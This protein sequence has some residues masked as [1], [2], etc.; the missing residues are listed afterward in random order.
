MSDT[1]LQGL[2]AVIPP[3]GPVFLSMEDLDVAIEDQNEIS[4]PAFHSI[5]Q[6][7]R[8]S[9]SAQTVPHPQSLPLLSGLFFCLLFL[10]WPLPVGANAN[11]SQ[12]STCIRSSEYRIGE[13]FSSLT[14]FLFVAITLVVVW[15]LFRRPW[16]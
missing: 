11:F 15:V 4:M 2:E 1:R 7:S 9:S 12:N 5:S 14:V 6:K 13:L 10:S 8:S 3:K 16:K